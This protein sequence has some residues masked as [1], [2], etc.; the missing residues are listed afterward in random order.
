MQ[1]RF[2]RLAVLP[3]AGLLAAPLAARAHDE[4]GEFHR[5]LAPMC[6]MLAG[7]YFH[8]S[9][10]F[11][12]RRPSPCRPFGRALG[13]S[14]SRRTWRIPSRSSADVFD[15]CRR[16]FP[17]KRG[18]FVSPSFPLQA[19]WPRPWRLELTTNMENSIAI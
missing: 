3:L 19:F 4:H 15:A 16:V 7:G 13:G 5:D 14:S 12:S 9:A 11:S 8:A 1:A 2:F 17:C 18:F 6:L 10:V